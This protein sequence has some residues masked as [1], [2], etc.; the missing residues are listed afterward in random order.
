MSITRAILFDMDGTLLQ[1]EKLAVAGFHRTFE[2]L[3]QQGLWDGPTP[4][5]ETLTNVLGMTLEQLWNTLL[6]GKSEE[7]KRI[8][9]QL[10]LAHEQHLVRE[11]ITDLY[12]GV[13]E[14]L[15]ELH[16]KGIA[17]FVASNGLEAYIDTICEHFGIKRYFTDLYSAGRFQTK[18]KKD[19]VAKL[20]RDY[21]IQQAVMVGDRH[22]DMEAGKENGLFTIGC[23]FGFARPGE[24]DQ[25][26]A[27][28]RHFHE[29]P[30]YLPF[31]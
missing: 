25:A 24:L 20:L 29:L 4:D 2:D 22:S 17:L 11:G 14:L 1:T 26:D 8:A 16:A 23:D 9:D 13:R 5:D 3:R 10:M 15:P 27:V 7:T 31:L 12:P 21:P 19:L 6:P 18:S 30:A 28:I